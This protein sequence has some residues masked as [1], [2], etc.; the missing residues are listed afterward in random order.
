M[1]S[2]SAMAC[3][4][5]GLEKYVEYVKSDATLGASTAKNIALWFIDWRDIDGI[6]SVLV[7]IDYDEGDDASRNISSERLNNI[8]RLLAPLVMH[9][10]KIEYVNSPRKSDIKVVDDYYFNT[11]GISIQPKCIETHSCCGGNMR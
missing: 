8:S 5:F 11:L 9:K 1:M 10:V 4:P 3:K 6:S 7:H 2:F